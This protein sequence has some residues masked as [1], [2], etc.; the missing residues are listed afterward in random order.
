[1][2][3]EYNLNKLYL[4]LNKYL[5]CS[6]DSY[7]VYNTMPNTIIFNRDII[8]KRKSGLD[9]PTFLCILNKC[10]YQASFHKKVSWDTDNKIWVTPILDDDLVRE[11]ETYFHVSTKNN[12]HVTGIRLKS[13]DKCNSFDIYKDRIYLGYYYP[14]RNDMTDRILDIVDTVRAEHNRNRVYVYGITLPPNVKVYQ[15]PTTY[16]GTYVIQSIP[17]KWIKKIDPTEYE[18]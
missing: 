17:P 6:A 11:D 16:D 8:R 2:S 3:I 18:L 13:R 12:L 10:G 4:L 14:R 5:K 15:D 7:E 1:M 9:M